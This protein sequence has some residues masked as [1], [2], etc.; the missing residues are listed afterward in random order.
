MPLLN[1]NLDSRTN[2]EY[3][4][5]MTD[6]AIDPDPNLIPSEFEEDDADWFMNPDGPPDQDID[7]WYETEGEEGDDVI[8]NKLASDDD[9]SDWFEPDGGLTAGAYEWLAKE[10]SQNGFC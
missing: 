4:N 3:T 9:L 1:K 7:Q 10:D 8:G 6:A 5:S 2:M